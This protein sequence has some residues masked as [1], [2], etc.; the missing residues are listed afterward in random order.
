MQGFRKTDPDRWE[1]SNDSFVKGQ[2]DQLKDI[3]R[4]KATAGSH[5]ELAVSQNQPAIEASQ[6]QL[7]FQ[8]SFAQASPWAAH[9]AAHMGCHAC[10][11]TD[12][13]VPCTG[14]SLWGVR[15]GS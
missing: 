2:K 3:T 12:S 14:G 8:P 9:C 4:R 1:F 6:R 13:W 7:S 5:S 15:G 11:Q 10:R